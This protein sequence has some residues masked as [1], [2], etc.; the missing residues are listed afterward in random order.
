[1]TTSHV[2]GWA[3]H[4]YQELSVW[5]LLL[6]LSPQG[7]HLPWF[8]VKHLWQ[9]RCSDLLY[10]ILGKDGLWS[11]HKDS[12]LGSQSPASL[13]GSLSDLSKT[14]IVSSSDILLMGHSILYCSRL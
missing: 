7:P 3:L 11:N 2:W 12:M 4:I 13:A 6:D 5:V 1:M 14:S 9:L 10:S 8:L